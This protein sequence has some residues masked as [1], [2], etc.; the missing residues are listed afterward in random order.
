MKCCGM[1]RYS[2]SQSEADL[3]VICRRYPPQ[4]TKIEGATVTSHFPLLSKDGLCGEFKP[5]QSESSGR[6]TKSPSHT[7]RIT[8]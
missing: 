5:R 1:C 2:L 8:S 6:V 7:E 4:I 3:V